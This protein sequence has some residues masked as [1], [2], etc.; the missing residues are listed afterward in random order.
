MKPTL[1]LLAS[2]LA[3]LALASPP[4]FAY[5]NLTNVVE[6]GGDNE[7]VDTIPAK[8]TGV[9]YN[10]TVN[11]E[12]IP[13]ITVGTPYT[14]PVFGED[15]SC[16]VDRVH[17]WN[18]ARAD[19]PIPGYLL[20]GEYIMIGNDNRDNSPFREDIYVA[21][22]SVVFVLIDNRCGDIPAAGA[23]NAGDPPFA[24]LPVDQWTGM[25]W[26]Y[27]NGFQPFMTGYN[28]DGDPNKPDEVAY[29]E[30]SDGVGPGNALNQFASIYYKIVDPGAPGTP[31]VSTG[32]QNNNLVGGGKDM[33]G[34]VVVPAVPAKPNLQASS[35]NGSVILS[36][37]ASGGATNYVIRRGSV[38]GGPYSD[39]AS[40]TT[41]GYTD[42]AVVNGQIYYYV[43][44]A[45]GMFGTNVSAQVTGAPKLAPESFL[46]KGGTN[47]V[48]L[49]W[50]AMTG[51]SSYTIKRADV[52]GG[53]FASIA[54]GINTASYVD[55]S[56]LAGRLYYYTVSAALSA[57][58]ESA[59]A[60]EASA[61]TA[62]SVPATFMAERFAA[63]VIRVSWTTT[64][65]VAPT[66]LVEKSTDGTIFTQVG[67]VT[68][69]GKRY[70]DVGLA[71]NVT[72]YYRVRASNSTGFS[73]YT[74]VADA[75]TPSGGVNVNF[76][77]SNYPTSPEYPIPGYLDDYGDAY[78]DRGNGYSYGWDTDLTG[79]GRW[80]KLASSPDLRYD[81]QIF[82]Y[83]PDPPAHFWEIDLANGLYQVHI[84]SGEPNSISS[85]YQ[86]DVEGWVSLAKTPTITSLWQDFVLT[87]KVEDGKLTITSG[88][89]ASNNK[90][91]FVDIYPAAPQPNTIT[92]Q[93]ASQTTLQNRP[94]SFTVGVGG[95]PEPYR[96]Q[97]Y[98]PT[99]LIAGATAATYTI[100]FPQ[101]TDAGIYYVV[102]ANA[103]ASIQSSNATLTVTPDTAGPVPVQAR[104]SSVCS[105]TL[106]TVTFDEQVDP[107]TATDINT[108]EIVNLT[109]GFTLGALTATPVL[110]RDG[111]T[112][113]LT[114]ASPLT[115]AAL[116][117]VVVKNVKDRALNSSGIVNALID[118]KGALLPSGPQNLVV[119][120]AENFDVNTPRVYNAGSGD[121]EYYWQFEDTRAGFSGAGVMHNLPDIEG[122]RP[123]ANEGCSLDFCVNFPAAGTYYVWVRGGAN[124]GA[125]NSV[126][127]G[128][129]GT[130][131][132]TGVNLQDGF[133]TPAYAWC[134]W[135]NGARNDRASVDVPGAGPHT[136][137]IFMREDGFF[138]DK[139]MLT[140]DVN[141]QPEG[142]GPAET[143]REQANVPMI[144]II[145]GSLHLAGSN[146]SMQVQTVQGITN[147]VEYKNSLTDANW[148]AVT[149]FTGSGGV[150]QITD[151]GPLP[152]NRFYRA[153][154]VIP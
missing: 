52:S 3:V 89:N 137:H 23:D 91:C 87:T 77:Q 55:T 112:V 94:V 104:R 111:R 86:W 59:N 107:T 36:W 29:D 151:S 136:V 24:G 114:A 62:P 28:R 80:A 95:G 37:S 142:L 102:V 121:T 16:M 11:G 129:D 120:E 101:A 60:D 34:V 6:F 32:E 68:D 42:T 49:S 25:H 152:P 18:G 149:S 56:V 122:S 105:G 88:P 73:G 47:Q 30:G 84:V 99:G 31:A 117:K 27:T 2:L 106:V 19:L 64:D 1:H 148:T 72:S 82:A 44:A 113:E 130:V 69:G 54:S 108:Y 14:V 90:I 10:A 39:L 103:G 92:T 71:A 146:V 22:R 33:Y 26:V 48:A 96:F 109:Y 123:G 13:G 98:G 135:I 74:A 132:P 128:I 9:T 76:G 81:T 21:G 93:P 147:I 51:A 45:E 78:A 138:A 118:L 20:G 124:D 150:V 7:A 85:T 126:H 70:Y 100:P 41:P 58:G 79:S 5:P 125:A 115:N 57:G 97:W 143:S 110:G 50:S 153:R 8:W 133:D 15:V 53:P 154:V 43:V 61:I 131:P 38:N 65:Q 145:S 139:L 67:S 12:P 66:T 63:K 127:I 40:Q 4:V 144:A 75:S 17:Q 83:L 46:A 119:A 141:Y 140:T 134:G 116:Y 35:R